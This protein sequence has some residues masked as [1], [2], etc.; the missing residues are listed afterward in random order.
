MDLRRNRAAVRIVPALLLAAALSLFSGCA[1]SNSANTGNGIRTQ[2][3]GSDGYLGTSN[4]NPHIHGRN[5]TVSD[6][7]AADMM[8]RAIGDMR[9]V[10]GA[11]IAF[12]GPDAFVTLKVDPG[13][14]AMK[15][16]TIEREAATILRFNFPR[17]TI[18]VRSLR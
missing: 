1:G 14:D 2:N 8:R 13:I 4:A 17:Y 12:N 11:N 15:V 16:P 7:N 18:H 3:Y 10:I 6:A 5:M 9:G